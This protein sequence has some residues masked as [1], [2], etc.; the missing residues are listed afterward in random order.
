M[1]GLQTE[2]ELPGANDRITLVAATRRALYVLSHFTDQCEL[3]P[4]KPHQIT[5]FLFLCLPHLDNNSLPHGPWQ[6]T[7]PTK[8]LKGQ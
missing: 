2:L 8:T 3:Q 5:A 6:C 7:G 4:S 1:T